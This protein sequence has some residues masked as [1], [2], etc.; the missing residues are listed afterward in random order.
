MNKSWSIAYKDT[1]I[2]FRDRNGLILMLVAPLVLAIIAG[3][4][5]GGLSGG[6]ETP[7]SDIPVILVNADQGDLGQAVVD[8]FFAD[9]LAELVSTVES[10]DLAGAK[11]QVENGTVRVVVYIPPEFSETVRGQ[12]NAGSTIA[13]FT[14]PS[15]VYGPIV[16]R[17]IVSQIV[18][19]FNAAVIGGR[20]GAAQ[21]LEH[22]QTLGPTLAQLP[23]VLN[24]T[25]RQNPGPSEATIVVETET[26][27]VPEAERPNALAYFAP[28]MAILFLMFTIFDASRSFLD[29]EREWTLQRMMSTPTAF[30]QIL[31]GKIGGVFL[32]GVLQLGVLV[33]VSWLGFRLSWGTSLPGLALMI[34]AIVAAAG[35]LGALITAIA[36]DAVQA[37]IVGSAIAL[38][39]AILGGNFLSAEAYPG[40]LQPI[41]KLTI[42]RWALDG[43]TDLSLRGGGFS[44]VI[45]E[46]LVLFGMAAIFFSLALWRLPKRF[47]R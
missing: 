40:W 1:L 13:L 10:G 39:F 22:Q 27:G 47:V 46:I 16:I 36:R 44:D 38:I 26:V 35:S 3:A 33:V 37:G 14:D 45:P 6:G 15:S 23:A 24:E 29:E 11:Q 28:S 18:N 43:L 25:L 12:D 8:I 32:T 5:F 4:A 9:D 21:L 7:I 31:A 19:G 2:R 30:G 34:V 20:V 41:S 42:N 17:S